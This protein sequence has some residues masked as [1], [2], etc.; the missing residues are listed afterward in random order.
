MEIKV[1]NAIT[2]NK[3]SAKPA[4][5]AAAMGPGVG[6]IMTCDAYNPADNATVMATLEVIVRRRK[7][8]RIGSKITKPLSQNTGIE[9][10]QPMI[11][12]ANSGCFF[13]TS[14]TTI[15]AN[16]MAAPVRSK[17]TP[18]RAPR[19]MTIPIPAKVELKPAPMMVAM[20]CLAGVSAV[21]A[22][23]IKG[24]PTTKPKPKATPIMA[25]KG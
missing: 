12:M 1:P 23:S 15:S 14:L 11:M 20:P 5:P 24:R 19:M 3:L 8:L 22:T 7:A 4:L 2:S 6:G 25:K 17:R 9:T 21:A 13:P 18:I 16:L 10:T